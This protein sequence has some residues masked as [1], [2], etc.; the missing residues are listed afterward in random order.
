[1]SLILKRV[2]S[3]S[4]S[5]QVTLVLKNS[6]DNARDTGD[7]GLIPGC[8]RSPG[9][10]RCQP[11]LVFLL[12]KLHGQEEPGGLRPMGSQRVRHN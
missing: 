7:V 8:R 1:M 9:G 12:E 3:K 2:G 11:T 10:G 5:S 4:G 6:L